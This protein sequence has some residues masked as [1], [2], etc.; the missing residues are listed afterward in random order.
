MVESLFCVLQWITDRCSIPYHCRRIL[1]QSVRNLTDVQF[2]AVRNTVDVLHFR[3]YLRHL[4]TELSHTALPSHND[5]VSHDFAFLRIFCCQLIILI[6][7]LSQYFIWLE[8]LKL[9]VSPRTERGIATLQKV[10]LLVRNK[11][12]KHSLQVH[13]ELSLESKL[14]G[15]ATDCTTRYLV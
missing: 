4:T 8:V 9:S 1:L 6:I 15:D 7:D 13:S 3:L 12:S 10:Q 2:C 11:I 14:A 5:I